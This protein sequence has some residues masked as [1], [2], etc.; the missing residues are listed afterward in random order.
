MSDLSSILN[1]GSSTSTTDALPTLSDSSTSTST[2]TTSPTISLTT[3]STTTST[4]STATSTSLSTSTSPTSSSSSSS[5]TSSTSSSTSITSLSTSLQVSTQPNGGTQTVTVVQSV[6]STATPSATPSATSTAS[7][8]GSNSFWSNKGAVAGTF[9]VV[10]LV[11]AALAVWLISLVIRRRRAN[12]YDRESEEAARDAANATAPAFLDDDDR[13][14]Y[15]NSYLNPGSYAGG[16]D[17]GSYNPGPLVP[18]ASSHGTY[19]QPP[20][21]LQSNENYPMA[22]FSSSQYPGNSP[23]PVFMTPGQAPQQNNHFEYGY[24]PYAEPYSSP[25]MNATRPTSGSFSMLDMPE[26]QPYESGVIGWMQSGPSGD[27]GHSTATSSASQSQ[28]DLGR[29]KSQGSRSLI[30]GRRAPST[31]GGNDFTSPTSAES[32]AAHYQPGYSGAGSRR[33]T[34]AHDEPPL[35]PNPFEKTDDDDEAAETGDDEPQK[36]VLKVANE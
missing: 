21:G 36:K 7:G 31:T 23:Y 18:S 4:S 33:S 29:T 3:S 30:D 19:N 14:T 32:Y 11:G 12:K 16:Y 20:M 1:I 5:S 34:I 2:T 26:Q 6:S 13:P 10:A 8:D 15:R 25:P 35:L 27:R 24:A 22:E 17:E 9:T 28:T